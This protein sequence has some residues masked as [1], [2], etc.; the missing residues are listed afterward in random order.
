MIVT[1]VS[2][3][4]KKSLNKTRRV[5]DA[6]ANRIGSRTWQTPITTEGLLAVKT[7]LRKTATKNTAVAC[8]RVKTR[9]RVELEWIVGNRDKFN[10]EGH[11]PVNYTGEKNLNDIDEHKWQTTNVIQYA[12]SIAGLFHDFGKAN[13]LFQNKLK[14]QKAKSRK[15]KNYE[16]YRH[17]WLS[18]RLFQAFVGKS[19]TDSEW[20]EALS[21][22]DKG[23]SLD[24][25]K[26]GMDGNVKDNHPFANLPSFAKLVGW[27]VL[28]HHKLPICPTWKGETP[29]NLS[30][31]R[32]WL[33]NDFEAIWN[34]FN[35]K[36]SD[37]ELIERNWTFKKLPIESIQWRSRASI[38]ASEVRT[39]LQLWINQDINWLNDQVFT[40]HISR[41]CLTLA[42]HYYS[43]LEKVTDEWR[44][45]YY[46]VYANTGRKTKQLK[47][48]LDEHLIGVAHNSQ[49]IAKALT[50][51]NSTLRSLDKNTV[52]DDKVAKKFKEK[53][54]WQD[55]ARI[56][57]KKISKE[58]VENGFFGINMAS[59]GMG[60]TLANAKI[61]YALSSASG[62]IRFSVALG[63]R[64]LT[65]QTGKEYR[66]ELELSDEQLAIAVGGNSVKQL[67]ENEQNSL[68]HK[69][70]SNDYDTGSESQNEF[71]D[72]FTHVDFKSELYDHSLSDWTKENSKL[73]SLLQAPLLVCTIDHLM[74]A[75]EG[76]KGGKQIPATLRLLTSDLVLDEPDDFGLED[77]P[78]LCRLVN[79]AG[80]LGSKV[81]LS[82]ATMPPALSYALFLSYKEGWG[83]YAKANIDNWS[84]KIACAWFDENCSKTEQLKDTGA[85]QNAHDKFVKGRIKYLN[86]NTT[87]KRI[88]SIIPIEKDENETIAKT[89]ARVIHASTI[90]LH[91]NHCSNNKTNKDKQLT[92]GLVRMANIN[93][94]VAVAK[95]L[96][97]IDTQNDTSIHYCIYHSRYPLAIR[98]Y[99]ENK[100][101]KILKRK[102][103][104]E[105]WQQESIKKILATYPTKNHIFIV[106][107][108]PVAEVGRDHD[109]DWAIVE[110][111]S[112]RSIIQLAGRVLRHRDII[113]SSPNILLLNK[114]YK[115]LGGNDIC[116]EKPGFESKESSLKMESYELT[117]ILNNDQY[118]QVNSI[119][120]IVKPVN[121]NTNDDGEYLNLV[122]LEHEAMLINLFSEDNGA[123]IWWNNNPQ[124]CGEVQR[125]QRFRDSKSDESYYLW[126]KD[127]HSSVDWRWK[128]KS[129]YPPRFGVLSGSG[130]EIDDEIN[131][132]YFGEGNHFWFELDAQVIYSQ[133][134]IDFK[135]KELSEI[136]VKFGEIRLIQY[137]ENRQEQYSYHPNLGLYKE[138]G[139]IKYV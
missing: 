29:P 136:S 94:L 61:M 49:K 120:R 133:L 60:K 118:K 47:Q 132:G 100:L 44:N 48:K 17:E 62:R 66:K 106:L 35:C 41:L 79:W 1:F 95:E 98:S 12:S 23:Y 113:P 14:P 36:E 10:F 78:A 55:D 111:S 73:E 114:N 74:P 93:P 37:K 110:P 127:E 105:I 19:K 109:Y 76:T 89:M 99:I 26:D 101:D 65:L 9:K 68:N 8:H 45:P 6:F 18:L 15:V 56:T 91:K 58:C 119:P 53:F 128:N 27:L 52:L 103:V 117:K 40:T 24:Y 3:C 42:D 77:F 116:F 85:F 112:M 92:I 7:L 71:T 32:N 46:E 122:E 11:V 126:L 51:L 88:A 69:E 28:T 139:D 129:I 96:L 63:L 83:Q 135:I 72:D 90:K 121:F 134:A 115:A 34:S 130:I 104:D 97:K 125:Q 59:T 131:L 50:R 4:E 123:N 31:T 84:G 124:W 70:N 21:E 64:T 82:T 138:I 43:S 102:S 20:L 16:P 33:K 75:T 13:L 30:N 86:T 108:S 39:K 137:N 5:L 57:A 87:I 38:V 2:Q 81:L 54:G 67:F 107:A 80:M 25:F 22:V